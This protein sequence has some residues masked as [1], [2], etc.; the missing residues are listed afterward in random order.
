MFDS[1]WETVCRVDTP[2]VGCGA[3][4]SLKLLLA[5]ASNHDPTVKEA[6]GFEGGPDATD[7]ESKTISIGAVPSINSDSPVGNYAI[8]VE[9]K[10]D[11]VTVTIVPPVLGKPTRPPEHGGR[12]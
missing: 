5:A 1:T 2:I 10:D 6:R 7:A 9:A 3:L 8:G 11:P 4:R 12:P